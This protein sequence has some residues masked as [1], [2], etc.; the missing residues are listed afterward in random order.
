MFGIECTK[1]KCGVIPAFIIHL[2]V[3]SL[4]CWPYFSEYIE[5]GIGSFASTLGFSLA[6][7]FIGLSALFSRLLVTRLGFRSTVLIATILYGA[8]LIISGIGISITSSTLFVLGYGVIAG[9]GIG[10]GYM[11]PIKN[12][13]LW[14]KENIGLATGISIFGFGISKFLLTPVFLWAVPLFGISLTLIIFGVISMGVMGIGYLM[15]H[16]PPDWKPVIEGWG[17]FKKIMITTWRS[18]DFS[19]CWTIFFL[20]TTVGISMMYSEKLMFSISSVFGGTISFTIGMMLSSLS[21]SLGR[22]FFPGISD[23]LENRVKL[24]RVMILSFMVTGIFAFFNYSLLPF[25]IFIGFAIYGGVFALM[26]VILAD[27]FGIDNVSETHG[28]IMWAWSFSGLSGPLISIYVA[29]S[30]GV[31]GLIMTYVIISLFALLSS[32]ELKNKKKIG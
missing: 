27:R 9:T 31:G 21:N 26:P 14:F 16:R 23:L 22:L 3:G 1:M 25:C 5:S 19:R 20:I 32:L 30:L 2:C 13:M 8:G 24:L 11:A 18:N 29:N 17:E 12:I 7:F 4:Y 6:I 28:M 10:L 15:I